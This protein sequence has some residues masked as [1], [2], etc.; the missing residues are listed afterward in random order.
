MVFKPIKDKLNQY[1]EV[2]KEVSKPIE[3]EPEQPKE[4]WVVVDELP[5]Q[6]IRKMRRES[7]GVILNFITVEE[8]L[9]EQANARI[10]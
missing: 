3:E 9:T 2:K 7:D 10:Q 6:T 5:T 1:Q 8:Y 4:E